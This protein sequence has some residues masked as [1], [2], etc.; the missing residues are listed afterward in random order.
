MFGNRN[1]HCSSCGKRCYKLK[2]NR[3]RR[4]SERSDLLLLNSSAS[5]STKEDIRIGN[6][7]LN[8]HLTTQI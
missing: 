2:K 7:I 5:K 3:I 4:V 8:R 1:D 6:L